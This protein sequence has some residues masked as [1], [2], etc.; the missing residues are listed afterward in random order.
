MKDI[1]RGSVRITDV[2]GKGIVVIYGEGDSSGTGIIIGEDSLSTYLLRIDH[3]SIVHHI[4][5]KE[6]SFKIKESEYMGIVS[7]PNYVAV[8]AIAYVELE[9]VISSI[10]VPDAEYYMRRENEK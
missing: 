8:N 10:F 9:F 6:P 5:L 7:L 1:P 4:M 3:K 2:G